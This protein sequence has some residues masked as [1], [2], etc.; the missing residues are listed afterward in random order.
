[1]PI[2]VVLAITPFNDPLNL[3][4]HKLGPAV[5][6]GNSVILKPATVTPLSALKLAEAFMEAGLPPLVMQVVTG[7]G[8]EIGDVLVP[9]APRPDDLLHRRRR[10]R[11]ADHQD[12]GHQED[13]HGAG[14]QL[15][16][17]RLEGR[18]HR[19]GRR[20][21]VSGAF[22]AAGQNCIGVQRIYIHEDVYEPVQERFVELTK[23]YKIGD[24]LKEE[25]TWAR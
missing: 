5:A 16:G 18:R 24:K 20:D 2:G 10:G 22:W 9:D 7:Y 14:L 23:K 11:A 25:R 12:G 1:M 6:A 3:V 15:A 4:A 13:R 8:A 17:H 19:V 21:C